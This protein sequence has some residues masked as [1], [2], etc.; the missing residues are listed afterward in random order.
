MDSYVTGAVVRRLRESK[1][2]TQ[3]ELGDRIGVSAKAIS[4]WETGRGLPDISLI[5]PLAQALGVSVVELMSGD[6][7]TNRNRSANMLRSKLYICP[8]CGNVIQAGGEAV[9]SCCGLTLPAAEAEEPDE[10]HS[11]TLE[12]VE[13]EQFLTVR[14]PMTK[15][16]YISFMACVTG[17]RFETVRL[18]PEG[19]AEARFRFR[20]H[21]KVYYYC[22]RH[23]L[24][25]Q[26]V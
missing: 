1:G 21:G 6:T 13:D 2:L 11:L 15:T 24:F 23:G 9:I 3:N 5:E 19:N 26:K 12:P 10:A 7:V 14:H 17:N 22:N 8:V 16:H 4:K 18:Y 25:V 20:G